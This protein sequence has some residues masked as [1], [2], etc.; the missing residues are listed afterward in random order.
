MWFIWGARE[1]EQAQRRLCFKTTR[2][3]LPCTEEGPVDGISALS[4]SGF[5]VD[6]SLCL[7]GFT[8]KSNADAVHQSLLTNHGFLFCF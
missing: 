8:V 1:A 3:L 7:P 6:L 2:C 4:C 5:N